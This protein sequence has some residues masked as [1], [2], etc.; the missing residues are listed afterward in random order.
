MSIH[1][2]VAL[3]TTSVQATLSCTAL[4]RTCH[5]RLSRRTALAGL[6]AT[7]ALAL[8]TTRQTGAQSS[9]PDAERESATPEDNGLLP[10]EVILSVEAV[11]EVIPEIANEIDTGPNATVIGAPIANRAVT[12]A[13]ADGAHRVVLSVDQYATAS[14]AKRAF[15]EAFAASEEVPGVT[16]EAVSGLGEAAL[17]GVVT[18]GDETHVGGGALFGALIVNATLQTFAGTDENKARVAELI[19]LQADYAARALDL[20]PAATPMA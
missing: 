1:L 2:E 20:S 6:V 10:R 3:V 11:Q 17:I 18:Q 15:D 7:T 16:T 8:A 14:D 4:G 5:L 9:T 19:Q 12:Y 13:T